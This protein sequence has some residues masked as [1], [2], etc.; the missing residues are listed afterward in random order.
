MTRVVESGALGT[1]RD[2]VLDV[3]ALTNPSDL[4]R[5]DRLTQLERVSALE[6]EWRAL[7][8]SANHLLPFV[9]YDWTIAWW[10]HLRESKFGV[11][12]QLF[13]HTIRRGGDLIGVAPMMITHRPSKGPLRSRVLQFIGADPNLTEVR[14]ALINPAFETQAYEAL[15][16]SLASTTRLWDACRLSGIPARVDLSGALTTNFARFSSEQSRVDYVIPLRARTPRS[17]M[18]SSSSSGW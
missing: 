12:D 5:V 7:E 16:E 13:V 8:R 17:A 10:Q 9:T 15:I 11:R 4:I 14:A 1:T 6:N 2:E 18:G 3:R